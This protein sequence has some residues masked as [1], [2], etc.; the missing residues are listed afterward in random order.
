MPS[1]RHRRPPAPDAA[2][3]GWRGQAGQASLEYAGV[4][5]VVAVVLGVGA[6]LAGGAAWGNGILRGW[7]Q[8]LC[9][10]TGRDCPTVELTACT[11]RARETGG[12]LGL[13]LT[14]VKLGGSLSLLREELSDGTVDITLVDGGDAAPTAALG[15]AG[16]MRLGGRR[17]GVAAITQAELL[18]RLGRRRVW[19]RPDAASADLLT[20]DIVE[21]LAAGAAERAL[22]L[23][24]TGVRRL[25]HAVG[26][27]GDRL[28]PPDVSGLSAGAKGVVE[29]EL[30]DIAQAS[31]GLEASLGGI[32]DRL[33]GRRTLVF[34]VEGQAGGALSKAV[35]GAGISGARG[36][37]LTVTFDREGS[38]L[39]LAVAVAG[40][41]RGDLQLGLPGHTASDGKADR[42]EV[43][44]RLDLGRGDNRAIYDRLVGALVPGRTHR[45]SGAIGALH[46]RLE[47]SARRDVTRYATGSTSYGA[48]GE[49]AVGVRVGGSAE[50]TRTTAALREAWTRPAGGTWEPRTDCVPEASDA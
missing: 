39:E 25:A 49:L 34:S 30:G 13:K 26:Y 7:E 48:D 23:V 19:H 45:L 29:A 10:V 40:T 44:S 41:G 46:D 35:G 4:L 20:R 12:R 15:A 33:T 5:A 2:R 27:D 28:P 37:T 43:T 6:V 11:V 3:T 1:R 17:V 21:H 36:V 38:P 9:R 14:F 16:G 32:R 18:V 47:T 50:L 8:A 31:A 24:G 42:V 22:P